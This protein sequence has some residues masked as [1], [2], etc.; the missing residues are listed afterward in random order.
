MF[1]LAY[2]CVWINFYSS[3]YIKLCWKGPYLE[4]C[5]FLVEFEN[6]KCRLRVYCDTH[7]VTIVHTS[8]QCLP[9]SIQR[10]IPSIQ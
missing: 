5:M 4:D 2:W 8:V 7:M 3:Y 10:Q 1:D 9:R 6:V